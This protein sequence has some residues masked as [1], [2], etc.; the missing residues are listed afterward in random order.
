MT[1]SLVRTR[2]AT[3]HDVAAVIDLHDTLL[4]HHP[5][6]P[7]PRAGHA[8]ARAAGPPARLAARRLERA[9]PS[10][11]ARSSAWPRPAR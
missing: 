3:P 2:H 4:P 1:T 11:A 8:G 10:S 9:R 6:P 7:L 5:A